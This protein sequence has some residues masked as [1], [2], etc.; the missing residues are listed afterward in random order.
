MSY[1][2]VCYD[3]CNGARFMGIATQEEIE[4]RFGSIDELSRNGDGLLELGDTDLLAVP[5]SGDPYRW[6]DEDEAEDDGDSLME[7]LPSECPRCGAKY[8]EDPSCGKSI[9][10]LLPKRPAS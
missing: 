8:Q 1:A 4:A 2:I 5:T 6:D 3:G 10:S 9:H 7:H